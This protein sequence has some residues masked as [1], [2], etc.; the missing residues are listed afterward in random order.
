MFYSIRHLTKFRYSGPVSESIMEVR[1]H[2]R[3]ETNQRC[4]T[5]QLWVSPKAR[6]FHYR[7]Y[8]SNIV[9]HFDVPSDHSQIVIVAEA[10]VDIQPPA[11]LPYSLPPDAWRDLDAEV[12][13]G[14][15]WETLMPSHF[16][17][18]S[19]A[20]KELAGQ[21]QVTRRGDPLSLL[22]EIN[23]SV[24]DW[25]EYATDSTQVDSPIED[26]LLSRRG[27]CQD[28]AHIMI[29]LVRGLDIPCR[30]VSGYLFHERS[31]DR[32]V[33]GASHA[34]VEAFLPE[35]GWVGFDP[36]HNSIAGSRHIRTAVGT[37]YA[38]VPP[39]RGTLKG[40][41][42]T[43]LTVAV[44]VDPSDVL[45]PFEEDPP[46]NEEWSVVRGPSSDILV[47]QEQQQQQ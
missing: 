39:T 13:R 43:E 40:K 10:V 12:E 44:R 4:L 34:W 20:L 23:A 26:A 36:T 33:D 16:A 7:D 45:P 8:L 6:V 24:Y 30:Y 29:A 42:K 15:F 9:H 18:P 22:R 28:F 5:F 47:Q 37:D 14:D 1:M 32:P 31:Q 41:V 17:R 2:P 46:A 11:Q 3:T 21:L 35:L 38:D 27:V 25:F 19:P